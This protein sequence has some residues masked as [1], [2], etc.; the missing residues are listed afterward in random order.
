MVTRI[1]VSEYIKGRYNNEKLD[2]LERELTKLFSKAKTREYQQYPTE[3][4]LINISMSAKYQTA[5]VKVSEWEHYKAVGEFE[6]LVKEALENRGF[7]VVE[8]DGEDDYFK[9]TFE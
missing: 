4:I 6:D 3:G 8:L 9:Y 7:E 5:Y 2:K 1:I